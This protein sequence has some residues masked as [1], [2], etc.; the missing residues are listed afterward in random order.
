MQD[1]KLFS[2]R[3]TF[4]STTSILF[5]FSS[6]WLTLPSLFSFSYAFSHQH[7]RFFF[8]FPPEARL[9]HQI[10]HARCE[11]FFCFLVPCIIFPD[12][13]DFFFQNFYTFCFFLFLLSFSFLFL[14]YFFI[15][16]NMVLT[17]LCIFTF[18]YAFNAPGP[19]SPAWKQA[20]SSSFP[21]EAW[22][23]NLHGKTPHPFLKLPLL[24]FFLKLRTSPHFS[25][26]HA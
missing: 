26:F 24:R 4:F 16:C 14:S 7:L 12:S 23:K 18:S 1:A 22:T 17:F 5:A 2:T 20:R 19:R 3:L 8:Y 11:T 15:F 21:C 13:L 6:A 25:H 9:G 10:F